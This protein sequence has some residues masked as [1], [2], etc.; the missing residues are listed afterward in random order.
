MFACLFVY[1]M[2]HILVY[3]LCGPMTGPYFEFKGVLCVQWGLREIL[4][5]VCGVLNTFLVIDTNEYVQH[6]RSLIMKLF[7]K[8]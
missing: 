2:K 8:R 1:N 4:T 7:L 5:M 3:I 6:W